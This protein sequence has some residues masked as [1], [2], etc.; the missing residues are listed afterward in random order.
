MGATGLDN[1]RST[2]YLTAYSNNTSYNNIKQNTSYTS[3]ETFEEAGLKVSIIGD[4]IKEVW[5]N[6]ERGW[7]YSSTKFVHINEPFMARGGYKGSGSFGYFFDASSFAGHND[8]VYNL[9][10]RVCLSE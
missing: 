7:F 10:F 4:A 2:K 6:D 1:G 3:F 8:Y 9:S 5:V